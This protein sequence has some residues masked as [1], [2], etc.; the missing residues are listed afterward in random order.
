[1][2][3]YPIAARNRIDAEKK[4][5][6]ILDTGPYTFR[7]I[8]VELAPKD[9]RHANPMELKKGQRWYFVTHEFGSRKSAMQ[10]RPT[11]HTYELKFP[12]PGATWQK[13]QATSVP[14]ARR[15]FVRGSTY[16]PRQVK[17]RWPGD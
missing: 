8:R 17:I 14:S 9:I 4:V 10:F 7:I 2:I 3:K 1:M 13:V 6:E 11:M 5:R 12:Y 16:K 15:K